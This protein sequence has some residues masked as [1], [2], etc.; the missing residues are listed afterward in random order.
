MRLR[1]VL[2]GPPES[3]SVYDRF[4]M[5]WDLAELHSR[6][7]KSWYSALVVRTR[8]NPLVE[9][10]VSWRKPQ[11]YGLDELKA[12]YLQAL[13]R[14]TSGLPRNIDAAR[15]KTRIT[16]AQSFDELVDVHRWVTSDYGGKRAAQGRR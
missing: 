13:D 7:K 6:W 4:G 9:V 11:S 12:K 1:V 3:E 15:L 5:R 2:D 8:L 10:Q 16:E 14:V